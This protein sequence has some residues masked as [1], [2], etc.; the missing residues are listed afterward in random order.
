[1]SRKRLRAGLIGCGAIG[2]LYD[3]RPLDERNAV[4]T[5]AGMLC[6]TPEIEFVCIAEIDAKRREACQSF[7]QVATA[8]HDY[9]EMLKEQRL[10]VIAVATPDETH[11]AI[12][13]DIVALACPRVVFTE[14][15]LAA[16]A[17]E[18][19]ELGLACESAR[20]SLLVDYVRR[21]DSNHREVRDFL[22][23]GGIG[24]VH[25]VTGQ[26]VRG[27]RHNGCQLINLIRFLF[28]EPT[29]VHAF[30][31]WQGSFADDPSLDVRLEFENGLVA[32]MIAQ[33]RSGYSFSVFDLEITGS[34]GRIYLDATGRNIK[35]Y[36]VAPHVEFPGFF[37]LKPK[38]S[39]WPK[40]TYGW[41]MISAGRQI[42]NTVRGK[43]DLTNIWREAF[44]DLE[45]IDSALTSAVQGGIKVNI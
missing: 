19:R 41:A 10:D 27:I 34:K 33:D 7:W 26:Y 18:A 1:M 44:R 11:A 28:G 38:T 22:L 32:Q 14:K 21:Y 12:I 2:S 8:Y 40:D 37:S 20:I 17:A 25:T 35:L 6:A 23:Q 45:I 3:E 5:H 24:H 31:P 16:T 39:L 13:R 29:M 36:T 9:R 42:V 43:T 15:P 4:Y 30:G